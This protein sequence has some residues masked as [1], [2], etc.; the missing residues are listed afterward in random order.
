MFE[1]DFIKGCL[2]G[3]TELE[4][5]DS[6]VEYWH[7]HETNNSLRDFLG[8]TQYEYTEWLKYGDVVLRDVLRCRMDETLFEE[9]KYMTPEEK[10][11]ARSYSIEEIERLKNDDKHGNK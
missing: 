6:Y 4:D 11:A 8:M 9:Y 3:D 2:F 1:Q 7:T 10:I 5:I